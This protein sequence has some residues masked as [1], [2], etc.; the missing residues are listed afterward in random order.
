[1]WH[2]QNNSENHTMIMDLEFQVDLKDHHCINP[3]NAKGDL[4]QKCE[5]YLKMK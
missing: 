5:H 3:T 1:M 2:A 4:K